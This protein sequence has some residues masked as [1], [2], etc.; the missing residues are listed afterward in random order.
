MG[1]VLQ[2]TSESEHT[3]HRGRSLSQRSF[4]LRHSS[5]AE[6]G[7]CLERGRGGV[8]VLAVPEYDVIMI[9]LR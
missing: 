6:P 2:A 8:V 9:E 3:P 4:R 1:V 7:F 5:Q